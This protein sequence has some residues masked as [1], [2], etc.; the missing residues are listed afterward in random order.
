[1]MPELAETLLLLAFGL[2]FYTL[3]ASVIEGFVNYRTWH[4][5]GSEH[6]R[7]Y[8]RAVGPRIVAC[9][10]APFGAGVLLT[11]SLVAWRPPAI[12]LWPILISLT[13]NIIAI[14]VTLRWQL[15]A[16][17]RL[18]RDGWSEVLV[19]QLIY[20][21]WFRFVPHA[22]NALLFLW[23]MSLALTSQRGAVP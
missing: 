18:D 4:R 6:F 15:P 1:M 10:V 21:E 11:G 22:L 14:V 12:P 8:H 9:L 17:R 5:V 13:L 2:A 20:V 16:Q 3:G 23:L 7:D 19:A